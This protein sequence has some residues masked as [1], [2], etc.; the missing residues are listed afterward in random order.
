[1]FDSRSKKHKRKVYHLHSRRA[2][3]TWIEGN[4]VVSTRSA[5]RQHYATQQEKAVVT[6]ASAGIQKA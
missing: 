2:L 6:A 1:L 3:P 5:L 4:Q